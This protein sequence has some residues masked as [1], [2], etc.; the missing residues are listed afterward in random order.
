[1]WQSPCGH[2]PITII[3]AHPIG[4]ILTF[5]IALG[6]LRRYLEE[7]DPASG[8]CSASISAVCHQ[9][10]DDIEMQRFLPAMW[11]A[12]SSEDLAVGHCCFNSFSVSPLIEGKLYA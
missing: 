8:S 10:E 12:V 11:G 7:G 2:S 4:V 1:M 5:G 9:P 3:T 6:R